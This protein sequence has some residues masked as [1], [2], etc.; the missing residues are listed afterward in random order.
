MNKND[1]LTNV[2]GLT[3]D[4]LV[5]QAE[6]EEAKAKVKVSKKLVA[7]VLQAFEEVIADSISADIT[8]TVTFG[9]LG[10]FIGK[11]VPEKHGVTALNGKEWVKPAHREISFRVGSAAKNI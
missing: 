8:D 10:K 9:K 1:V 11:E 5:E 2:A 4:I 3:T 7:A 6:T